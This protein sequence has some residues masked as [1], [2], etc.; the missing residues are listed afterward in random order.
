M[1]VER[2]TKFASLIVIATGI[3]W[4]FYWLPVR[5]MEA[6]GLAGPWGTAVIAAASVAG[7][8]PFALRYWRAATGPHRMT[9]WALVMGGGAFALYSIGFIYGRVALVILLFFLTPVWSTL[10]ARYVMGWHT[11]VLRYV[12]IGL[13]LCGLSLMLSAGGGAPVP[14]SLGE[15]FG[16]ISGVCW[17]VTTTVLRAKPALPPVLAAWFFSLGA[18][19]T[20]LCLAVVLEPMPDAVTPAQIGLAIGTGWIWWGVSIAGLLWATARLDPARVGILLMAEVLIGTAGAA[21]LAGEV[22]TPLE[23]FGGGLVVVAAVLEVWPQRANVAK[24]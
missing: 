2:T 22:L 5:Q 12:A 20:A 23:V 1:S 3:L 14:K 9:R 11:P 13:G 16:L 21:L 8:T 15:W 10:I 19:A 24:I 17:S 4:G 6:L 7:L 18:L